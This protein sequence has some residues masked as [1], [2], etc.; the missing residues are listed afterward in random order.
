MLSVLLA[1]DTDGQC[2]AS[3]C[4]LSQFIEEHQG[5]GQV[6]EIPVVRDLVIPLDCSMS[7]FFY[8]AMRVLFLGPVISQLLGIM[9]VW[10]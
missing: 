4:C 6:I 1:V 3:L 7:T 2:S 9:G 10:G 8:S 5:N